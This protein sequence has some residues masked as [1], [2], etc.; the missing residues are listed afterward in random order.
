M[1]IAIVTTAL[2]AFLV[3]ATASAAERYTEARIIQVETS[4]T[5]ILVFLQ[6]ISGDTPPLGN[7]LTNQPGSQHWLYLAKSTEDID[8]RKHLLASALAAQV[9]GSQVRIRWEDSGA[10]LNR[11]VALLA[12]EE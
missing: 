11:I 8:K 2:A 4:D 9:T 1:R 12:R 3:A 10:D 5:A 7:G 6:V